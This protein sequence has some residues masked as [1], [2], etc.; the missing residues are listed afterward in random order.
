MN[1]IKKYVFYCIINVRHAHS[2]KAHDVATASVVKREKMASVSEMYDVG[3]EG[4]T[5]DKIDSPQVSLRHVFIF[6]KAVGVFLVFVLCKSMG[7]TCHG[8]RLKFEHTS[9]HEKEL[10]NAS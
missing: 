6:L 8:P 10:A 7:K 3:W 4:K 5:K 1:T 2:W 9:Q